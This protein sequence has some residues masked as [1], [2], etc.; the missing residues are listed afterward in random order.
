MNFYLTDNNVDWSTEVA[1]KIRA[2]RVFVGIGSPDYGI[3]DS[4]HGYK[5][6]WDE[7]GRCPEPG[8]PGCLPGPWRRAA[9][10]PTR[11]P[12]T[13]LVAC[14]PHATRTGRGG[15]LADRTLW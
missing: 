7:C 8:T 14:C 2:C 1:T 13:R 9:G 12:C 5:S 11:T 6:T 4:N 10:A 3:K 15:G